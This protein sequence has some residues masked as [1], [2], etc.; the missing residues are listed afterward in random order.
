MAAGAGPRAG[1]AR[2]RGGGVAERFREGTER[3]HGP[4]LGRFARSRKA[5]GRGAGGTGRPVR[6]R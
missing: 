4:Q 2:T 1:E 5:L 6:P 3:V